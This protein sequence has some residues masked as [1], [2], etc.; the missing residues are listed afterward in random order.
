MPC[1]WLV[2]VAPAG[3]AMF[4]IFW[5]RW[6]EPYRESEALHCKRASSPSKKISCSVRSGLELYMGGEEKI[7][8]LTHWASWLTLGGFQLILLWFIS[9]GFNVWSPALWQRMHSYPLLFQTL[10]WPLWQT[11]ESDK[12]APWLIS[13]SH[14]PRHRPP[15]RQSWA[16]VWN[17]EKG[18]GTSCGNTK[19]R[20][21]ASSN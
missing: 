17:K 14:T 6:R 4:C 7:C 2:S 5:A 21:R 16:P 13:S 1:S 8:S 19:R 18:R 12:H 11:A 3:C 10:Q 20:P 15:D 9:Y